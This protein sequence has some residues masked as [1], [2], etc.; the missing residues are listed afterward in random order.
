MYGTCEVCGTTC[1]RIYLARRD[2]ETGICASCIAT[3]RDE[4]EVEV[5]VL[6]TLGEVWS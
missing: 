6:L 3:Q 5:L 2:A 1:C 4:R